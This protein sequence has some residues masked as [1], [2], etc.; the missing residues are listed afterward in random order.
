MKTKLE[1]D[2]YKSIYLCIDIGGSSIK[3]GIL[4]ESFE[5]S[6]KDKTPSKFYLGGNS[7]SD[8]VMELI[9][10]VKK[11]YNISGVAISSTG[12]IDSDNAK[13]LYADDVLNGYTGF[14]FKEEIDKAFG[15]KASACNDVNCL[16]L[17]QMKF[18]KDR[19][20]ITLAI[21]TGIGG[22]IV[23]KNRLYE[24]H[25]FFAGE[26]GLMHLRDGMNFESLCAM[27]ALVNAAK[28]KKLLINNG[29]E[30]F[31]QFDLGNPIALKI[32]DSFY[33]DMASGIA[34]LI[35]LLAPDNVI[36]GGG[37]SARGGSLVV[38]ICK[39]LSLMMDE[40]YLSKTGIE[41]AR[42]GNDAAMIGA[43]HHYLSIY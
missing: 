13:V 5:F 18:N 7:L 42:Y 30:L 12:I 26:F 14:D 39:Y 16:A 19:N 25:A 41:C 29:K 33:K 35:Y 36:I 15:L 34:N 10:K 8:L 43:L 23:I 27:S 22:A 2:T 6:Y 20:F 3:Y 40:Y 21:G 4:N 28:E 32:V 31:D 9:A 1:E 38:G 17:S 37:I 11:E 24:G